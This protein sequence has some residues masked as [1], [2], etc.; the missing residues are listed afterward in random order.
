MALQT[1][2]K[3]LA[4]GNRR[5]I[6]QWLKEGALPAGE[7]ARRLNL[8]PPATSK[9]LAVLLKADLV[10]PLHQKNFIFYELNA[11]VLEE[12]LLWIFTLKGESRQ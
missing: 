7:I 11:S 8:S 10:R 4:D 1:A 2:L 9:H 3:A 12:V 6:L 5:A